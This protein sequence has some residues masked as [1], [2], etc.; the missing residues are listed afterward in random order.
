MA[1]TVDDQQ[2]I[3]SEI[4]HQVIQ[5][6]YDEADANCLMQVLGEEQEVMFSNLQTRVLHFQMKE[7]ERYLDTFNKFFKVQDRDGDGI[8][9]QNQFCNLMQELDLGLSD[10]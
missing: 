10:K 9:D 1:A 6:M 4:W 7:H 3:E 8:I 5:H 2:P